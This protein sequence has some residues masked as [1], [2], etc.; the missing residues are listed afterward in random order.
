MNSKS[1]K[2]TCFALAGIVVFCAFVVRANAGETG[3]IVPP[4]HTDGPSILDSRG[5]PARLVSVNWYGF[6]QGEY[7]AGGLDRVSLND[8][9]RKIHSMGFNSVRLPWAN[10]I[11]EENPYV[12]GYALNAN[13]K[14]RGKRALEIMDE[15]IHALAD[16]HV[17]VIL[18][19]HVSRSDWCCN[20]KDGNGLWYN[21]EY[22]ESHWIEDWRTLVRRYKAQPYVVAADLRNELRS[23]AQWGGNDPALDWHAAAERGGN[24]ILDE[25]PNLL[26]MV[27]GVSY[28]LDFAGATSLPVRLALPN[29]LVYS[30]HNYGWSQPVPQSYEEFKHYLDKNWGWLRT[31]DHAAPIWIGEIGVCQ[32]PADCR[33]FGEW[34]PF[35]IR[36]LKETGDSWSYW[37]LNATQ[38]SGS[39]RLYGNTETYGLLTTDYRG[40]AA[41]EVLKDLEQIG[42]YPETG[43]HA[44]SPRSYGP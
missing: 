8:I 10:Q 12:P 32:N 25:N 44:I 14:L 42:L 21:R 33:Q 2:S 17:M 24:A 19:N 3:K 1:I 27:E 28:S 35:L 4:L 31:G 20:D 13:P 23:S 9:A 29:R 11:V 15:V 7:V 39:G 36:Y 38:S 34:F 22:P 18:D 6:D 26:I 30:P 43:G 40:I 5:T 41:P 16:E 37:A